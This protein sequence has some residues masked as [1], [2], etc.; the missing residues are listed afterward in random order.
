MNEFEPCDSDTVCH[1]MAYPK[2]TY[3]LTS[4]HKLKMLFLIC[5]LITCILDV[6]DLTCYVGFSFF[7]LRKEKSVF[8]F[9][10]LFCS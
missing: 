1:K 2:T 6:N 9:V 8:L 7:A 10:S 3:F 4:S 5:T